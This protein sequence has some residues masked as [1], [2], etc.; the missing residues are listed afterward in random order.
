MDFI[1]S[2]PYD[3]TIKDKTL[4]IN[5]GENPESQI[6]IFEITIEPET[7]ST[8]INQ[9]TVKIIMPE[10]FT[11]TCL[12]FM[13]HRIIVIENEHTFGD[14]IL[15][16]IFK[17]IESRLTEASRRIFKSENMNENDEII[18]FKDL[19]DS[20][21]WILLFFNQMLHFKKIFQSYR[22]KRCNIEL[23]NKCQNLYL[24][25]TNLRQKS[26]SLKMKTINE[27]ES[28]DLMF[29]NAWKF[30]KNEPIHKQ[31]IFYLKTTSEMTLKKLGNEINKFQLGVLNHQPLAELLS[32][33]L[34]IIH[35][36]EYS[37]VL[38]SSIPMVENN[39]VT[40]VL[41]EKTYEIYSKSLNKTTLSSIHCVFWMLFRSIGIKLS[42]MDNLI[43]IFITILYSG[44]PL[45]ENL[46]EYI[47]TL[48]S[49]S[50]SFN[51]VEPFLFLSSTDF[52][53]RN[54]TIMLVNK[55]KILKE[56]DTTLFSF[57]KTKLAITNSHLPT[58]LDITNIMVINCMYY[59]LT[60]PEYKDIFKIKYV[61]ALKAKITTIM[62][63]LPFEESKVSPIV[64]LI[65]KCYFLNFKNNTMNINGFM[66]ELK[67]FL[68]RNYFSHSGMNNDSI[69]FKF[70]TESL[71][72]LD[73]DESDKKKVNL[74]PMF[75]NMLFGDFVH[76]CQ[77]C[78]EL[79]F[80]C[81]KN[82]H[83]MECEIHNVCYDC[84]F[85]IF[86]TKIYN[87]GQRVNVMNFVCPICQK[88]EP[89][90]IYKIPENF[91]EAP[92]THCLCSY[93]AC[94]NIAK[95]T[96]LPPCQA[97]GLGLD[98]DNEL[99][100]NNGNEQNENYCDQ[101]LRLLRLMSYIPAEMLNT[102]KECPGCHNLINRV[103]G[104]SHITCKCG[105]QF[106]WVCD[107][108]H[109]SNDITYSHPSYCRGVYSWEKAL[110]LLLNVS[111]RMLNEIK[112]FYES[113]NFDEENPL[114]NEIH[115]ISYLWLSNDFAS[116]EIN[117]QSFWLFQT[118]LNSI[119]V[120]NQETI[121]PQI[122]AEICEW[123]QTPSNIT[124]P[125]TILFLSLKNELLRIKSLIPDRFED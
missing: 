16:T 52:I 63:A 80:I 34:K 82:C 104:C 29:N 125:I 35:I 60:N 15:Y 107:Y 59:V 43:N 32:K 50:N 124:T 121:L 62:S 23:F 39:R 83:I 103:E 85:K 48:F 110:P 10:N 111:N 37:S 74:K 98:S 24:R 71:A 9:Y 109:E 56:I 45:D 108:T 89:N 42:Q 69:S 94:S 114:T 119:I 93:P 12:K 47:L 33:M 102:V 112:N 118:W 73:S 3:L 27:K 90:N 21:K 8:P 19:T 105:Q 49:Q 70:N 17:T 86:S 78:D 1:K 117:A 36:D 25:F 11:F 72:I 44:Y 55:H 5:I 84:W 115:H 76:N 13:L 2:I 91:Y 46:K 99:Q 81:Q 116:P 64:E 101:H 113:N 20:E 7:S 26:I 4:T 54:F 31:K 65:M 6:L 123:L 53:N 38:D 87:Q 41:F 100:E 88:P 40:P 122:I 95:M 18:S 14:I 30:L 96:T 120:P 106:C 67:T 61:K 75:K 79:Y 28:D 51:T 92:E 58:A 68:T 57:S 77:L 66:T 97:A 22:F